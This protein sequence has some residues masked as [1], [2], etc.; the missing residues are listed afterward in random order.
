MEKLKI[1]KEFIEKCSSCYDKLYVGGDPDYELILNKVK[2]EIFE[3]KTLSRNTFTAIIDWKSARAKGKIDWDDFQLYQ[4]AILYVLELPDKLKLA[5]LCGLDGIEL[6]VG[7][8]ILHFMYPDRF[9]IVD[10]RVTEVLN[11]AGIISSQTISKRTYRSYK[12]AIVDIVKQ[13]GCD[14][15]TIDRALFAYHKINY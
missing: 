7:S 2:D 13:T 9:P 10:Y 11:D 12:E 14:I 3:N 1:T 6:P 5:L 4:I 15:R 8:T